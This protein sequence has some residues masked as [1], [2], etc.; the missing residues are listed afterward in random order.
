MFERAL[1]AVA[2][3]CLLALDAGVALAQKQGGTLR[4]P[5]RDNPPSASLH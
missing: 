1:A 5:Q 2:I 3:A 4:V